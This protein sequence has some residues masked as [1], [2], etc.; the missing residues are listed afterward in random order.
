MKKRMFI[1]SKDEGR[2]LKRVIAEPD[3]DGD[4]LIYIEG[5]LACYIRASD[6]T[7]CLTAHGEELGITFEA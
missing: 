3:H 5:S 1:M 4:L 6:Y 7:I 2:E